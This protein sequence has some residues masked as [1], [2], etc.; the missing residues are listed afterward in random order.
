MAVPD[1]RGID[2][3]P[4]GAHQ[5]VIGEMARQARVARIPETLFR[6]VAPR[7]APGQSAEAKRG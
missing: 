5:L 2:A 6:P 7:R 3:V 1:L 4:G